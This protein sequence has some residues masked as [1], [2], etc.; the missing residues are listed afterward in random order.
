[1]TCKARR[2]SDQMICYTCGLQWDINDPEPPACETISQ[3]FKDTDTELPPEEYKYLV[4][5]KWGTVRAFKTCFDVL[6]AGEFTNS[7]KDEKYATAWAFYDLKHRYPY[8]RFESI[9]R[10]NELVE[11]DTFSDDTH[12]L[13]LPN[14]IYTFPGKL[15]EPRFEIPNGDNIIYDRHT[16][17]IIPMWSNY[18]AKEH[19]KLLNKLVDDD[20]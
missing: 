2:Y 13:T 19:L 20:E 5:N 7:G 16:K 11:N 1:M 10:S 12:Y 14:D 6:I 4:C 18:A 9:N 15:S 8:G 17:E 3:A